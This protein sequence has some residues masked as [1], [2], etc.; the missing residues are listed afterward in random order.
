MCMFKVDSARVRALLLQCGLSLREFAAQAGLNVITAG[1]I[2]RDN[3][4][5]SMKTVGTLAKFFNVDGES[6][7]LKAEKKG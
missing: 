2:V 6:L 4:K 5:V 1:K 7:I 3:V